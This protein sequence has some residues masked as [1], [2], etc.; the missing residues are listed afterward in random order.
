[1]VS[2][3]DFL[4]NAALY[5]ASVGTGPRFSGTDTSGNQHNTIKINH[6]RQLFIDSY[7]IEEANGVRKHLHQALKHE[8]N[9]VLCAEQPWEKAVW[10]N[11]GGPAVLYDAGA[12]Q[13]RMLYF[14]YSATSSS[15]NQLSENYVPSY[16]ISTDGLHW[17]KPDLGLVEYGASTQNSILPWASQIWNGSTNVIMDLH[18][19]TPERRYKSVYYGHSA[20]MTVDAGP[21]V[22]LSWDSHDSQMEIRNALL[23]GARSSA[24]LFVSFSEDEIHWDDYHGNPVLS[25]HV[26]GD[27]HSLLGWDE[28]VQKYVGFFRPAL[29]AINPPR[30]R[31]I[32]RSESSDFIHWT[33]PSKQVVLRPD[34]ADP[35]GTEF[36]CL[37][38][39]VYEDCYIGLL[40]IY[41]N[42]PHW[43]W[44]K[45]TTIKDS[46]LRHDQ[47]I[48]DAQLVTSRDGIHWERTTNRQAVIPVGPPGSWDDGLVYASTP[49][50]VGDELWAYYGGSN[51]RHTSES[52]SSAGKVVDGVRRT[53]G[54]GLAKWRLD[55]F[56]SL[57][58]SENEGTV[59]TKPL[60]FS[61][62]QLWL[63]AEA[64]R[65][66][67]RVEVLD[68]KLQPVPGFTKDEAVALRADHVR[69]KVAWSG[70]M[71]NLS[72]LAGKPI[73]FKFYLQN[74]RVYSFWVSA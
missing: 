26:V 42:D 66:T 71:P 65:G 73:R 11:S 54:I 37:A 21:K 1:M 20:L 41:H 56:V 27:T 46:E 69:Q 53:A 30:V 57:E 74:A 31:V 50:V 36:Y 45:G 29:E 40:W 60:Q 3:R 58:S 6:K 18:D 59:I 62:D 12:K 24:G 35:Q 14:T 33:E 70:D 49:L 64:S 63:N 47:Q 10:I 52:L 43:P 7:L 15:A 19:P 22:T 44:P 34:A 23:P 4:K 38:P 51:M 8:L 55:G 2:R 32:G 28:R 16:A 17:D 72:S 39:M 5:G 48:M 61:G 13:F 9:P 25:S 68:K 67:I